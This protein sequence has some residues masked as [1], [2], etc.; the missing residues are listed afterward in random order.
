MNISDDDAAALSAKDI[1]E[2]VDMDSAGVQK[3]VSAGLFLDLF[4]RDS[5]GERADFHGG[6]ACE[7]ASVF[8]EHLFEEHPIPGFQKELQRRTIL[9]V[10]FPSDFEPM[11]AEDFS[12][13]C[14]EGLDGFDRY[15]FRMERVKTDG[16]F[17]ESDFI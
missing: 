2:G 16:E 14:L 9:E 1:P 7:A 8:L 10:L 3:G 13:Q 15:K 12:G 5:G 11:G 17:L 6:P 4:E